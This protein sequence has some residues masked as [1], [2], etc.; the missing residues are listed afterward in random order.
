MAEEQVS[1]T[2]NE[3]VQSAEEKENLAPQVENEQSERNVKKNRKVKPL[4]DIV[5]CA[6]VLVLIAAVAGV[7]LGVINWVTYVDPEQTI[8]SQVGNKYGVAAD[9]VQNVTSEYSVLSVG[10]SKVNAVY[11]VTDNVSAFYVTASGAYDGTIGFVVCVKDG[12]VDNIIVYESGETSSIGGNV[13]KQA[14]LDKYNGLEL[15][16]VELEQE[17]GSKDAKGSPVYIS[18]ATKTTKAVVNAIVVTAAAYK[19]KGGANA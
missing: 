10:K 19:S 6:L 5:R 17:A 8:K 9:T 1:L 15:S 13:L 14:N 18:G 11:K 16:A 3:D 4:N 2:L 12:K 7:L